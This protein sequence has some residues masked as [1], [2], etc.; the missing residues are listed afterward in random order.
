MLNFKAEDASTTQL[1]EKYLELDNKIKID[2]KT[3]ANRDSAYKEAKEKAQNPDGSL[4]PTAIDA[5]YFLKKGQKKSYEVE[6]AEADIRTVT[7]ELMKR[8]KDYPGGFINHVD[9][10]SRP[11]KTYTFKLVDE[12]LTVE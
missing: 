5:A 10:T 7:N 3:H 2:Q 6:Q 11:E 9:R 8:L 1:L 4:S 12:K